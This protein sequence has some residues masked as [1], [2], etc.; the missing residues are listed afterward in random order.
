[1][2]TSALPIFVLV[3]MTINCHPARASDGPDTELL[4][5]RWASL[6]TDPDKRASV[7]KAGRERAVFCSYCHGEDGNDSKKDMPRLAGQSPFYLLD[8]FNAFT[9]LDRRKMVMEA[10]GQSFTTEEKVTLAMYYSLMP[11]AEGEVLPGSDEGKIVY[12]QR[13]QVCHTATGQSDD[14]MPRIAGQNPR[15][16]VKTL[17][18]FRSK[19][20]KWKVD[21]MW[22]PAEGLTDQE[23]EQL[24]AYLSQL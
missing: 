7:I 10:L 16:L 13:C 22:E 8:Q 1:V 6:Q 17:K 24:A 20:P 2:K 5:E 15:Y 4:I 11:I 14:A 9:R 3:L 18:R 19:D 21:V 23:I 12:Q